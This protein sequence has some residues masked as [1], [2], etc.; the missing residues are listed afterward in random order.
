MFTKLF[1][2]FCFSIK[3]IPIFEKR[4]TLRKLLL[5]LFVSIYMIACTSKTETKVETK[6]EDP[7][8]GTITSRD[9]KANRLFSDMELFAKEDYSFVNEYMSADFTLKT[10]GDTA[11]IVKGRE[12]AIAYWK[13]LHVLFKDL[14]FTKG[15]IATFKHNNGE[16][17]SAYFGNLLSTGK[18]SNK[19]YVI[20]LSVWILWD[21]DKIVH[22]SD[23]FDS[24]IMA[25]E[26]AA[27]PAAS[28]K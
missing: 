3:M 27:N 13:N 21:G 4:S 14:S 11:V 7:L 8:S 23:M 1:C 9:E 17:W 20:P 16:T 28:K 10:L 24:K 6:S 22:Q 5:C 15:R 26:M 12:Q 18:F 19:N 25:E 2:Q